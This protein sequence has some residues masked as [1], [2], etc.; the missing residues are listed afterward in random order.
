MSELLLLELLSSHDDSDSKLSS[1]RLRFFTEIFLYGSGVGDASK[2]DYLINW[3]YIGSWFKP[4]SDMF[5]QRLEF[6]DFD[7]FISLLVFYIS[8]SFNSFVV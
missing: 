4:N 6:Y 5:P 7:L 8:I 3:E 2:T 1:S